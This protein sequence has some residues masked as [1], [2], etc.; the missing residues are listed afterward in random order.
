MPR[1]K[2]LKSRKIRAVTLSNP[3]ET[4][5]QILRQFSSTGPH[6]FQEPGFGA[7]T[8]TETVLFCRLTFHSL[9]GGSP[10]L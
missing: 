3:P 10:R 8:P 5:A 4:L 7:E 9:E 1:A 6:A 2:L